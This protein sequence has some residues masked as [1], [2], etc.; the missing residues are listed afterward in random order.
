MGISSTLPCLS[1]DLLDISALSNVDGKTGAKIIGKPDWSAGGTGSIDYTI[2]V[3]IDDQHVGQSD[4][5]FV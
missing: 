5:S 3:S 4:V 1:S 2:T